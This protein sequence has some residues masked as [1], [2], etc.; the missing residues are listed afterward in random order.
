MSCI[1]YI[2]WYVNCI[3]KMFKTNDLL[4][5]SHVGTSHDSAAESSGCAGRDERDSGMTELKWENRMHAGLVRPDFLPHQHE[6]KNWL[7]GG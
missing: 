1:S 3:R 5:S 2:L 6:H 4:N 7:F